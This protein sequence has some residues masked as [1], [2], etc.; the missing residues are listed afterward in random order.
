M[1]PQDVKGRSGSLKQCAGCGP[2]GS[3]WGQDHLGTAATNPH[4]NPFGPWQSL[5]TASLSL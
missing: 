2:G 3:G 1:L 5:G 4:S